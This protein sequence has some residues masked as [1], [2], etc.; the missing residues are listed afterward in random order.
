MASRAA[1]AARSTVCVAGPFGG[2]AT[3]DHNGQPLEPPDA[4][5]RTSTRFSWR[6]WQLG[7]EGG[8]GE[9]ARGQ[10]GGGGRRR[11]LA[12]GEAAPG[13]SPPGW[14]R[15]AAPRRPAEALTWRCGAGRAPPSGTVRARPRAAMSA[16]AH[17]GQTAAECGKKLMKCG[18]CSAA[19]VSVGSLGSRARPLPRC[20]ETSLTSREQYCGRKC[21]LAAWPKHKAECGGRPVPRRKE[22]PKQKE[23]F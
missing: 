19:V 13:G 6:T 16:C 18:R 1:R 7:V 8:V 21:Q 17:C 2:T 5:R 10:D 23:E 15:G 20:R 14:G 12:S 11:R 22:K 4:R 9:S 3:D